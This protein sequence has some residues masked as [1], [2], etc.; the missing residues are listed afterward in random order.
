MKQL[1]VYRQKIRSVGGNYR[2]PWKYHYYTEATGKTS[3]GAETR[4]EEYS[5]TS[6][7][8]TAKRKGYELI[9]TF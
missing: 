1:K 7:R 4:I 6:L 9:K 2:V 3:H 8:A 5:L